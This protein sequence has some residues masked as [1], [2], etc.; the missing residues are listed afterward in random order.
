MLQS[1]TCT[2]LETWVSWL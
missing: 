2:C 1:S